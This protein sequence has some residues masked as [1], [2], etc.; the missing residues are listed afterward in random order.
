L[1][2]VVEA[3]EHTLRLNRFERPATS[4]KFPNAATIIAYAA[5][6]KGI[7]ERLTLASG[8]TG[9]VGL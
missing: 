7:R 5:V 9:S 2:C 1:S 8:K 6:A 3:D 4:R